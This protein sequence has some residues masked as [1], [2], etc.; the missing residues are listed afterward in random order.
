MRRILKWLT[1]GVVA[2]LVACGG[3]GG[4]GTGVACTDGN[5]YASFAYTGL[6]GVVGTSITATPQI[7]GIPAVCTSGLGFE[8]ASGALP[9]GLSL[10]ADTGVISGVARSSGLFTFTVRLTLDHFSGYLSGSI[11]ANIN[12]SAGYSFTGWELMT[13]VAPFQ[14]DF[15]IGYVGNHLYM[16]LRGFYT[17]VV[18]TYQSA[19]GGATWTRLDIVAPTGDPKEFALASD[20]TSIYFSGGL[21]GDGTLSNEVWRFNGSA[22]TRMAA[23]APFAPRERHSM[24]IHAGALYVLGGRSDAGLLADTWKSTD[25]GANW[26][27]VSASGFN[28]RFNFCAVSDG[29]GFMYVIGGRLLMPPQPLGVTTAYEDVWR[30]PDGVSWTSL[31]VS[32]TSPLLAALPRQTASCASLNGRIFYM[33]DGARF[34]PGSSEVVSSADGVTWAFEPYSN[35]L[36]GL[37]PGAITMGGQIY[38]VG[39]AGTSQRSVLRTS[40]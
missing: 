22:W 4:G 29:A 7:T 24:V 12:A 36:S 3:G 23:A 39:G 21:H 26:T 16:V 33:G 34:F 17:R 20:G 31:P 32:P 25:S 18:E 15:R 40:P 8:L 28:P 6:N 11:Y 38:V 35:S 14:D 37:S 30:S 9:E 19:D 13:T 1:T 10:N 2:G 27:R 5:I